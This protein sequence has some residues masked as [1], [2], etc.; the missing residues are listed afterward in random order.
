MAYNRNDIAIMFEV[1]IEVT[2]DILIRCRHYRSEEERASVFR[3]VFSPYFA[4]DEIVR[5][6][7]VRFSNFFI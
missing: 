4:F 3:I 2:D 7:S 5:I 1:G 6:Y